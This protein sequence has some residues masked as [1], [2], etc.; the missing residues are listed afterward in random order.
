LPFSTLRDIS[1]FLT[2]GSFYKHSNCIPVISASINASL[3][4][5]PSSAF[6]MAG[7]C[8]HIHI[9]FLFC[10]TVLIMPGVSK[11]FFFP[12]GFSIT[13]YSLRNSSSVMFFFSVLPVSL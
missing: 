8:S 1:Y 4:L 12:Y 3:P 11:F 2:D 6:F 10:F 9:R 5:P 7:K 13:P